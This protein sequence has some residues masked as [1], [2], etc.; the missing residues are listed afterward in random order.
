MSDFQTFFKNRWNT[1]NVE[2]RKENYAS[3][4]AKQIAKKKMLDDE[5]KEVN[6]PPLKL[7]F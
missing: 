3:N 5:L 7:P 4:I 2:H 6:P 1:K